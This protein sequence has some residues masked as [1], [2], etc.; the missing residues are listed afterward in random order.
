MSIVN[1]D[2]SGRTNRSADTV[3]IV[4]KKRFTF[5][6]VCFSLV[7]LAVLSRYGYLMLFPQTDTKPVRQERL[8]GRG[9]ILDRNGRL[10]AM[11]TRLGNITLWRPEAENREELSL[12]LSHLLEQSA[13]EIL[14]RI[15]TSPNDFMYLKKQVNESIVALIK[16]GISN[17][18]LRGVGIDPVVSRIYPERNL[19]SQ[20]IGFVG[21][22]N[23]G[24]AGIEY[25]MDRELR[26]KQGTVPGTWNRG[27]Q[28]FLTI[29]VNVQ[30]ILESIASQ[31]MNE[32]KAEAIMFMAIDP[33]TGDILGS[34]SLPGYDPNNLRASNETSR[35]D[36]PAIWSYE[37]GSV[38]KVF[39]LSS[40]MD[41][42]AISR[43]VFYL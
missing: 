3:R 15:N 11:E 9:P 41:A 40:L 35:M 13:A 8:A 29:D 2:E 33:R 16:A 7:C 28:V 32:N 34:A 4:G 30:Y 6:A 42:G 38:F 20:I 10:L 12:E 24:L 26:D 37:P 25:A 39:S 36:R 21:D 22:E 1:Y 23:N 43:Y 14:D 19:A 27:S 31:V 18:R 5:F 17:G